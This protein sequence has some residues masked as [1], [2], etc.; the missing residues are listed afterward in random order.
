MTSLAYILQ[1]ISQIGPNAWDDVTAD[2]FGFCFDYITQPLGESKTII[3][4]TSVAALQ[5]LYRHLPEDCPR[6]G[7]LAFVVESVYVNDVL[8][9]MGEDGL[10]SE[11]EYADAM[12]AEERDRHAGENQ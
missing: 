7:K 9:R 1:E 8:K 10:V 12:N 11:A 5:W 2:D 4:P 6:Y 3:D